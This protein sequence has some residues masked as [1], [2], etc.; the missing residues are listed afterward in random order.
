MAAV[1]TQNGLRKLRDL[2]KLRAA[3]IE[4]DTSEFESR[5]AELGKKQENFNDV[6]ARGNEALRN[7]EA[8]VT[9]SEQNFE[10][11]QKNQELYEK[12]MASKNTV[13]TAIDNFKTGLDGDANLKANFF[14]MGGINS[15]RRAALEKIVALDPQVNI[16][17]K[18]WSRQDDQAGEKCSCRVLQ[19]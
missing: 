16:F 17:S 19:L 6:A 11:A 8:A 10:T 13:S 15:E 5:R 7:V 12:W 9:A 18:K 1:E 14:G 4:I 2:A 3:G